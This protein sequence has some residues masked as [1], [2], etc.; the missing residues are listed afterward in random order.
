MFRA[1]RRN[2]C[3]QAVSTD[4][5][6]LPSPIKCRDSLQEGLRRAEINRPRRALRRSH[7]ARFSPRRPQDRADALLREPSRPV[8]T[9]CS[10]SKSAARRCQG[11]RQ[12]SSGG[13]PRYR[14]P[15]G[16]SPSA[17]AVWHCGAAARVIQAALP[18]G[19]ARQLAWLS[20]LI[21]HPA[22]WRPRTFRRSTSWQ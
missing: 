18:V 17:D 14:M 2:A 4:P 22:D 12:P 16:L 20:T 19:S 21:R 1:N 9:C 3:I 8:S 11:F 10:S 7:P 13:A 6:T 5:S 15:P